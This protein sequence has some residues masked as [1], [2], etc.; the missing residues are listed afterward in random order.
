MITRIWH[1][2]TTHD[3]ADVYQGLLENRLRA[4][5]TVKSNSTSDDSPAASVTLCS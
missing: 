2:W 1:G 4:D 3:N 5:G